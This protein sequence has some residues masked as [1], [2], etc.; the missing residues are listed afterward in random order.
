MVF[1][2]DLT[3]DPLDI[4][5]QRQRSSERLNMQI[6]LESPDLDFYTISKGFFRVALAILKSALAFHTFRHGAATSSST[7][8]ICRYIISYFFHF[9]LSMALAIVE[10]LKS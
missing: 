10:F 8:V 3:I 7:S 2:S 9:K 6:L 5:R 1:S 4:M